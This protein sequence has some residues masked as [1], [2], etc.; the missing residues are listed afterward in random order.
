MSNYQ[1]SN[2][3]V[4]VKNNIKNYDMGEWVIVLEYYYKHKQIKILSSKSEF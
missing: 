4:N 1:I 3:T 2:K